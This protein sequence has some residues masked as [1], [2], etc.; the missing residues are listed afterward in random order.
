METKR[1]S[2]DRRL[3]Q[4]RAWVG[5]GLSCAAFARR[6]GTKPGTLAWWKW[7]FESEGV[8]LATKNPKKRSPRKKPPP[9]FV[10]I[11]PP[12]LHVPRPQLTLE[13]EDVTLRVPEGFDDRTLARVLELLRSA[14]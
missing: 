14:R 4:V 8:S 5:S 3:E 13:L 7:K 12:A 10:E 6:V 9:A 2:R 11:T 1:I